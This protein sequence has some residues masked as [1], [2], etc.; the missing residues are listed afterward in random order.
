MGQAFGALVTI[1]TKELVTF[2]DDSFSTQVR[3][4][5]T[6]VNLVCVVFPWIVN[7]GP[8]YGLADTICIGVALRI[9]LQN[10]IALAADATSRKTFEVVVAEIVLCFVSVKT[11][12]RVYTG[13]A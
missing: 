2:A 10:V 12:S 4:T 7:S 8:L 11:G 9:A 6:V 5:T 13:V 3:T 1:V